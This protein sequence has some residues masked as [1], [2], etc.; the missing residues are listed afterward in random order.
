MEQQQQERQERQ[1]Q[2]QQNT[3]LFVEDCA[4]FAEKIV[5]VDFSQATPENLN[6]HVSIHLLD[7]GTRVISNRDAIEMLI[8]IFIPQ[9]V[10][11]KYLSSIS[12]ARG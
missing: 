9:Q 3:L 10:A 4:I 2:Q 12:L 1:Q 6:R 8:K 5:Y 7:G 11:L